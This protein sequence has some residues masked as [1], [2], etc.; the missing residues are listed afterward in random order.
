MNTR[1]RM[2]E[3]AK[4]VCYRY[5][6]L[7][8]QIGMNNRCMKC[9][10]SVPYR[11]RI[12]PRAGSIPISATLDFSSTQLQTIIST[13]PTSRLHLY[14][15]IVSCVALNC[16]IVTTSSPQVF[17]RVFPHPLVEAN[18]KHIGNR[19]GRWNHRYST[20][21]HVDEVLI[22]SITDWQSAENMCDW[23]W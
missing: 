21:R 16:H 7:G 17:L 20:S 2:I 14:P 12:L 1:L 5:R 3:W 4:R 6:V 15:C 9:L 8:G 23:L 18:I 19:N 13:L 10:H 11:T 22:A